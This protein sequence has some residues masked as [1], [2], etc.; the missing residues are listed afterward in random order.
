MSGA[1]SDFLIV[2]IR[3]LL[4]S[5]FG[6]VIISWLLVAGMRNEFILRLDYILAVVTDPIMRP[7][8]RIIPPLGTIDIT[9]MV[10]II[11][12]IIALE[13]VT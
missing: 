2:F 13:I 12:L 7:L 9:P 11:L 1:V 10:A 5:I 6:R 3:L 4:F 8:R